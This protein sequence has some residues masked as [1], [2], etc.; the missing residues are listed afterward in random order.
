LQA[1]GNVNIRGGS[2]V[3]AIKEI[4]QDDNTVRY[5]VQ[6]NGEE[7]M[8]YDAVV[9]A[10]GGTAMK[11]LLSCSPPLANL[12]GASGWKKFRGV[13]C[14]AVR[15]FLKP[16][17][18]KEGKVSGIPAIERA[19][20]DSPIVVCGPNVG[21]IPELTETGFCIY[22]LQRLHEEFD[23]ERQNNDE[24]ET[25]CIAF[26]IDFFRANELT[27]IQDDMEVAALA[28]N[29]LESALDIPPI[30]PG[31]ILDVSVVRA[32]NA[33]SHF[34]VD[35]ASWSPQV[36]LNKQLYICGDWIDRTGHASWS[37]EK[38]VVTA[39]QAA[40]ALSKDFGFNCDTEILPAASDSPQLSTLRQI[41]K[42]LRRATSFDLLPSSPWVFAKQLFGGRL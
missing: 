41:A 9:L 16:S 19:M 23:L 18:S 10:V 24:V 29:A 22:D 6:V 3:T 15:L 13:T 31:L 8:E 4:K 32:N 30:D 35:S 27:K 37:T 11:N 7:S 42:V 40:G 33:V 14:C 38:A 25:P 17:L 36:K 26:E 21:G 20:K 34:C 12:P 28:L 39:R 1:G 2:K 5:E